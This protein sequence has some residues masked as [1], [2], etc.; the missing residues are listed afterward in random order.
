MVTSV[1]RFIPL[2]VLRNGQHR[3][4]NQSVKFITGVTPV[5]GL[6]VRPIATEL[7]QSL[8]FIRKEIRP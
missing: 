1:S 7:S 4:T 2:E 6:A 3:L 5:T 8:K